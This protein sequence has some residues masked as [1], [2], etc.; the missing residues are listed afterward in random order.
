MSIFD[1]SY[2]QYETN[3][4]IKNNDEFIDASN[5]RV[6]PNRDSVEKELFPSIIHCETLG[7]TYEMFFYNSTFMNCAPAQWNCE[8]D[9]VILL[10]N[11][12]IA[13]CYNRR[14]VGVECLYGGFKP[15]LKCRHGHE[16]CGTSFFNCKEKKPRKVVEY[17]DSFLIKLGKAVMSKNISVDVGLLEKIKQADDRR[18]SQ[19][20]SEIYYLEDRVTVEE[21]KLT[22]IDDKKLQDNLNTDDYTI[23]FVRSLE[24]RETTIPSIIPTTSITTMVSFLFENELY[25]FIL[26]ALFSIILSRVELA[27]FILPLDTFLE[28]IT[29]SKMEE[30]L[31]GDNIEVLGVF[32]IV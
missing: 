12:T 16:K 27:S 2:C 11:K 30:T 29:L 32:C 8:Y 6:N 25:L 24:F 28:A 18:I 13:H 7:T 21:D 14:N 23:N 3:T 19:N 17:S 9:D 31:D 10:P 22:H 1:L 20:I 26:L 15:M 4:S 5:P